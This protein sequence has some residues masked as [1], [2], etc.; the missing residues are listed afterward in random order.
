[1]SSIFKGNKNIKKTLATLRFVDISD[2]GGRPGGFFKFII[3]T[4]L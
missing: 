3:Q 2:Q 1:M 4:P